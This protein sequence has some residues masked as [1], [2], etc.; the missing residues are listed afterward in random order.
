MTTA[1]ATKFAAAVVLTGVPLPDG[2]LGTAG[3]PT[4]GAEPF[5]LRQ[6]HLPGT[7]FGTGDIFASIL[8]AGLVRGLP[9]RSLC[10][11]AM[12]FIGDAIKRTLMAGTDPRF[13]VQYAA[14]LPALQQFFTDK[15]AI[16]DGPQL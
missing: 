16:N 6:P 2:S 5:V 15:E 8:A 10:T 4:P 11:A 13:G 12:D 9:L 7:Y 3:L 1:L 14:G